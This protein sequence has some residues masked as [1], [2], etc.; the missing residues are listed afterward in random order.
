MDLA[1]S[2]HSGDFEYY[3][4]MDQIGTE[5]ND[6]LGITGSQTNYRNAQDFDSY[7]VGLDLVAYNNIGLC[8]PSVN[9]NSLSILIGTE[10]NDGLSITGISLIITLFR[11]LI[12]TELD[13]ISVLKLKMDLISQNL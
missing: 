9:C 10:P 1:V 7:R 13:Q 3:L 8:D 5:P 6:G 2:E 4:T 12:H 11:S